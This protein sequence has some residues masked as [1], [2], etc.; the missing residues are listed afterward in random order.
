MLQQWELRTLYEGTFAFTNADE[1]LPHVKTQEKPYA[2]VTRLHDEDSKYHLSYIGD[3]QNIFAGKLSIK[4]EAA[5]KL[6]VFAMVDGWTQSILKPIERLLANFLK[7]LPNDGVYDQTSSE[8][9]AR[10]KSIIAGRSYGYD[11]SAATDRLPIE[12]QTEILNLILPG[13]GNLWATFLVKR[14]YYMYLPDSYAK[15]INAHAKS[16]GKRMP[17]E[18]TFN[19]VNIPVYYD[20]SENRRP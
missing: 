1:I 11:L 13:L 20:T 19:G 5:G 18:I 2:D 16:T 6:R 7:S 14:E 8:K 15:E 3:P 12:L 17:N 9:R 10:Q 4:E